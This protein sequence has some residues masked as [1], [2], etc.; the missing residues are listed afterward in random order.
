LNI[1]HF[2]DITDLTPD[3]LAALLDCALRMKADRRAHEHALRGRLV[4][5]VFEKPSLRTR[6][7]FEAAVGEFGA[8]LVNN[9]EPLRVSGRRVT[10]SFFRVLGTSPIVG[11]TLV[12]SDDRPGAERVVVLSFGLWQRR[13]GGE[14]GVLGQRILINNEPYIVVGVMPRTFQFLES[15]IGLWVPA[16]FTTEELSQ[17]AHYLTVIGRMKPGTD[18]SGV[19]ADLDAIG[20][21]IAPLL[22]ADRDAPRSVV[23]SL[24]DAVSGAARRPLL[25]LLAAVGVVLLITCANLAGLLL[26]RAA[27]RGHELALRGALGASRGRV[28]RQLLTE[29]LLLSAVG[30]GLGLLLA[31]WSLAFL[32]QLVP[33]AMTAFAEPALSRVTFAIAAAVALITG[34]LFGLAPAMSATRRDLTEALKASGRGVSTS[35]HARGGFVIAEV[36]LT[37]VLLVVAGL[38]LQTFYR[39]RY[40]DLGMRPEGLLTL[41]TALPEDRYAEQGRRVAFYDRVLADVE[42]LPGVLAAGYTTSVPL[43][44]KGAASEFRIEGVVPDKGT[45]YDANHRQVSASYLKAIGMPLVRGRLFDGGDTETSRPVVIINE[46]MARRYWRD[47]DPVGR[48]ITLDRFNPPDRWLTIVGIVGDVRQMGLDLPSRPELYLPYRQIDSRPWFAPRDLVVRT[49]GDPMAVAGAVKQVV[50]QVDPTIAVSNIRALDEILDDDVA[51]RRVGTTLLAT[52]AAFALALAVV[53]IYGVIAYFVAQH[54]PEIGIRIALGAEPRDILRLVIFTGLRLALAGVA[55]GTVAGLIVTRL[56]SSLLYGVAPTD[57]V[58]FVAA[59]T[60][61]LSLAVFASYVPARQATAVDPIV[62]LRAE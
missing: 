46:T 26:A 25:L 8:V 13:F 59:A 22:P 9:G 27:S 23:V 56:M 42:H 55:L 40:A 24:K 10:S 21:R 53:G 43:E 60:L 49:T 7:S 45:A 37:L 20:R 16:A 1:H 19:R 32:V 41:R 14:P 17:A 50:R 29:S 48:R 3:D 30:L 5:L 34:V 18:P 15:Y 11:R 62:A 35:Q 51:S 57:A 38:L 12:A 39:V 36:A 28:V 31:R 4:G 54:A 52:F 6:V 61:L 44:W 2:L 47:D 33:P 58:T